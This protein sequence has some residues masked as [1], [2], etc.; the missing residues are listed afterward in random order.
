M[1]AMVFLAFLLVPIAELYLFVQVASEIGFFPALFWIVAV[2]VI[3]AWLVKREGIGT[4]RR[5][6]EK[7]QV[8]EVPAREMIGGLL[9]LFAGALMLTP[10]FLTDAVGLLLLLPPTRSLLARFAERRLAVGPVNVINVGNSGFRAYR[11]YRPGST[12]ASTDGVDDGVVDAE[13]WEDSGPS[14]DV[15]ELP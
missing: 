2:S 10:G 9:I 3:G 15:R 11:S 8:G 6:Q 5:A 4:W 1:F 7:L 14:P 13:S 12:S